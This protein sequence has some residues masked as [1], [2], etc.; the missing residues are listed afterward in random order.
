MQLKMQMRSIRLRSYYSKDRIIQNIRAIKKQF[1]DLSLLRPHVKTNKI[2]E[3]C[4]LMMKEGVTKFKCA[5]IAEAEMLGSFTSRKMFCLPTS[6]TGRR[7]N[8]SLL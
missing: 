3:V 4:A 6:L 2:S 8:A 5:T 7:C 1:P